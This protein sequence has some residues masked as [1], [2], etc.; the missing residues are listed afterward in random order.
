[1]AKSSFSVVIAE[2]NYEAVKVTPNSK[3]NGE[4]LVDKFSFCPA[5]KDD[6]YKNKF[7]DYGDITETT[8]CNKWSNDYLKKFEKK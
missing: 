6:Y 3:S 8:V 4:D 7:I 5:F 1:M 2:L